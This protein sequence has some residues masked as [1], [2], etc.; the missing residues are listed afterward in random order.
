MKQCTLFCGHQSIWFEFLLIFQPCLVTFSRTNYLTRVSFPGLDWRK[1]LFG[2]QH[3]DA[4]LFSEIPWIHGPAVSVLVS[5]APSACDDDKP[6]VEKKCNIFFCLRNS[7]I[8]STWCPIALG[9]D[10]QWLIP[11]WSRS[12]KATNMHRWWTLTAMRL[13]FQPFF[14][15]LTEHSELILHDE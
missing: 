1:T 6:G 13:L 8:D 4:W 11:R 7:L 12:S 2:R 5:R 15:F 14:V 3:D 10:L 9:L